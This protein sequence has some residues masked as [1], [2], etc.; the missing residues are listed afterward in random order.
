ME[1]TFIASSTFPDPSI[2]AKLM[3]LLLGLHRFNRL[4]PVSPLLCSKLNLQKNGHTPNPRYYRD[5]HTVKAVIACQVTGASDSK[6]ER[7]L[8]IQALEA[9]AKKVYKKPSSSGKSMDTV[10]VNRIAG[11]MLNRIAK[12]RMDNEQEDKPI[13]KIEDKWEVGS[14]KGCP[15]KKPGDEKDIKTPKNKMGKLEIGVKVSEDRFNAADRDVTLRPLLQ[16]CIDIRCRLFG[17][18]EKR[19]GQGFGS[20]AAEILRGNIA[21]HHGN[22]LADYGLIKR[23]DI[24]NT[25]TFTHLYGISIESVELYLSMF[26]TQLDPGGFN[27]LTMVESNMLL[28]MINKR[29][30]IVAN[31]GRYSRRWGKLLQNDF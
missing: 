20:S 3:L 6:H 17:N 19:I 14:G 24:S 27:L 26:P 5:Y 28:R 9:A 12:Q 1:L 8:V 18:Y 10:Y 7:K 21:A 29:A 30:T 2:K 13:S 23:G 11:R 31:P 22:V 15:V 16:I 25:E 4:L